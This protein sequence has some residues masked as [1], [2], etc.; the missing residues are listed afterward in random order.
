[1]TGIVI[2]CDIE[3]LLDAPVTATLYDPGGAE[4][5]LTF[6][7]RGTEVVPPGARLTLIESVELV[8]VWPW[9][10]ALRLLFEGDCAAESVTVPV[11][12]LTLFTVMVDVPDPP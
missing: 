1:M 2:E 8:Q 7:V 4:P 3:G 5:Q 6:T 12:P 9:K 11:N 10:Q